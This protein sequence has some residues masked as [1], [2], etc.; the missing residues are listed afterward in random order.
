MATPKRTLL[1]LLGPLSYLFILLAR[2]SSSMG[3]LP[4]DPGYDYILAGS[5]R[6]LGTLLLG[7][8]YFHFGARFIAL[9]T[10]W[11][12]LAYQVLTLSVLVHLVWTGC[13]VIIAAVVARESQHKW[14]GYISGFLL[15]TAP[16]ASESALGNVGNL[17]W[18]MIT[19]LIVACCSPT[20][21]QRHPTL[22]SVLAVLTGLTNPLTIL[23]S[24][25]LGLEALRRRRFPRAQL[26]LT[27]MI[28]G[29]LAI[30]VAKVGI[31]SAAS[32]QSAKVTSPWNGMGLFWWSGLVGPI[33]VSAT[34][35]IILLVRQRMGITP[36]FALKIALVA[37]TLAMVSYQMGGIADR[38]FIA[39]MTLALMATLLIQHQLFV[40]T[41]LLQRVGWFVTVVVLLVPTL[42]WFTS[43][44]YLMSPP[45]WK[46]EI[47]RAVNF[48]EENR[49]SEVDISS[50]ILSG[51]N[52]LECLYILRE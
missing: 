20:S 28:V 43:G 3:R 48:C 14:L 40:K 46:S 44:S 42:K 32:G 30:Q 5:E 31:S 23:C 29:T 8:P 1:L 38:Y 4:A 2:S 35:I 15:I 19:A 6:G 11:F 9:I 27:G 52:S 13:A 18:P 24:I 50:S 10:S 49:F 33:V 16:H 7:D 37:G 51:G 17:K 47:A 26:M 36:L 45:L 22:I 21:I 39:P 25:P 41:P 34:C 12:P